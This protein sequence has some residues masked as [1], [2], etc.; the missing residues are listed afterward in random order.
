MTQIRTKHNIRVSSLFI[1]NDVENNRDTGVSHL[2]KVERGS[3]KLLLIG[4][5]V[6]KLKRGEVISI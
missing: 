4:N 2:F 3:C 6:L 5:C 1:T